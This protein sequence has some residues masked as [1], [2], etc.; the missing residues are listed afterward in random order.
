[1]LF[2]ILY[3]LRTLTCQSTKFLH[4]P[5]QIRTFPDIWFIPIDLSTEMSLYLP[6]SVTIVESP[7]P[8]KKG[9]TYWHSVHQCARDGYWYGSM[10]K[11]HRGMTGWCIE[12]NI[13]YNLKSFFNFNL[14]YK[15]SIR[16]LVLQAVKYS[17]LI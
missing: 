8:F 4:S 14:F 1:M 3:V 7:L 15:S 9:K 10:E 5:Y 12:L 11:H 17:T 6:F 16:G 2:S 13:N